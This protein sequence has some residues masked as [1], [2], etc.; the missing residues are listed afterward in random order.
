M[1]L[2]VLVAALQGSLILLDEFIF[3]MRRGLP[4]WERIGH[5]VDTATVIACLLFLGFAE[6]TSPNELIY[7]AMA[8]IS[9]ICVTK[10]EFVHF[11][12][13]DA[14]EMWMH[15]V[16]FILHPLLLVV[17]YQAWA[18][19]R[20]TILAVA[21]GVSVFFVWQVVYWNFL[22]SYLRER[23]KKAAYRRIRQED[24]YEYFGE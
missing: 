21:A 1:T 10:D 14:P 8:T 2:F 24:L 13:C 17:G 16:L 4:R 23:Q 20:T 19:E 3:H 22:E 12:I 18:N 9:C 11:K 5:P 15:G 7:I 6:K